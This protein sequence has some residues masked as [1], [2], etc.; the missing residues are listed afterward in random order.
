MK[1]IILEVLAELEHAD[2]KYTDDPMVNA[3][4]GLLTLKCEVMELEREVERPQQ[5]PKWL[6]KEAVQC[7]AMSLKFIRDICQ[8]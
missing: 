1:D 5:H 3:K 2:H 6:R 7:A 8:K 4:V